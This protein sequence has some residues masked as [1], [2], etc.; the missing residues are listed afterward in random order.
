MHIEETSESRWRLTLRDR[1]IFSREMSVEKQAWPKKR[2]EEE[3]K[4]RRG[5]GRDGKRKR[6]M[7]SNCTNPK[8]TAQLFAVWVVY[9]VSVDATPAMG[10]CQPSPHCTLSS[11]Q[12]PSWG[13]RPNPGN[14]PCGRGET[15]N[16]PSS[17]CFG[18]GCA[19]STHVRCS[20]LAPLLWG[21]SAR[22]LAVV[23]IDRG[24]IY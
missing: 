15:C 12:N 8:P 14:C 9:F 1:I 24:T 4:G 11:F 18:V 7:E 16:H 21:G 2:K 3:K 23:L 22:S 20:D 13:N 6:H 10:W 5:K 19:V 17:F